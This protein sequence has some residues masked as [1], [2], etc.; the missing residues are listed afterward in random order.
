MSFLDIFK[1]TPDKKVE[2]IATATAPAEVEV[3]EF[4]DTY[5]LALVHRLRTPLNGARWALDSVIKSEKKDENNRMLSEGY[6]K[7]IDAINIV[8][9]ILEVAEIDSKKG[10]FNL[11][12]EMRSDDHLCRS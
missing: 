10:Q 5:I 9:Q 4:N 12:K 1:K 11:Q 2:P 7:I 3:E 6:N 8:N